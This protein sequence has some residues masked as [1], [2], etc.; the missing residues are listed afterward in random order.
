[1]IFLED[2]IPLILT[3]IGVFVLALLVFIKTYKGKYKWRFVTLFLVVF[4]FMC[5]APLA[6]ID[7]TNHGKFKSSIVKF[8]PSEEKIQEIDSFLK[9]KFWWNKEI[10]TKEKIDEIKLFYNGNILLTRVDLF[11]REMNE[12]NSL[13]ESNKQLLNKLLIEYDHGDLNLTKNST[14]TMLLF[15]KKM[16][17]WVSNITLNRFILILKYEG[18]VFWCK[19]VL[20]WFKCQQ[21]QMKDDEINEI[22][23]GL[24]ELKQ[25]KRI[26]DVKKL[27]IEL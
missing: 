11:K 24:F 22:V 14:N 6:M 27:K 10:F 16:K 5:L 17:T 19:S 7:L 18:N 12:Y 13:V 3:I 4:A 15:S 8:Q 21:L 20:T 2:Y 25:D 1:M 9:K 23:S 26:F